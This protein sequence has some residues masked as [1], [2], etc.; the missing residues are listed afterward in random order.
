[1]KIAVSGTHCS[2]KTTL[3]EELS[4]A[5]PTYEVVPEPYFLLEEEG[6]QFAEMPCLEDF[7]LQLNRSIECIIGAPADSL[8]ERCPVDFLAYL[9]A[10]P[11]FSGFEVATWLPRVR[12]A[13]EQ[14]DLIAFLPVERPDRI[15]VP[16]LESPRLRRRVHEQLQ[17]LLLENCWGFEVRVLEVRGSTGERARRVLAH[18]DGLGA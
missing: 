18:I 5:L 10:H 7:E 3:V 2:G 9:F 13:V 1:M 11:E 8:V 14:L 16:K 4:R 6:H 12:E 15:Q 17:E